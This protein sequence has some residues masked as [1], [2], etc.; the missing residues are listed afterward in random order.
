MDTVRSVGLRL[1]CEHAYRTVHDRSH[2]CCMTERLRVELRL[3]P[4][5]EAL[6]VCGISSEM[7]LRS[8]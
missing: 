7:G 4:C 5:A 8:V 2:S 6:A 3:D 1:L